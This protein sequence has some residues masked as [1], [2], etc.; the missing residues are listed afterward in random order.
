MIFEAIH[1]EIQSEQSCLNVKELCMLA[2]VSRSGYYKYISEDSVQKRLIREQKDLADF[3]L[4]K[5]AYDY[6]GYAKGYR[7]ICMRLARMGTLMN[8]KKVLRLMNKYGLKC[9]I[10]KANPYRRMAKALKT[11]VIAANLVKRQFKSHGPRQILLTDITYIRLN[12]SFCYLSVIIDAFTM[13]VL[14]YKLSN[15]L[16]VD[17]VLET[18]KMLMRNHLHSLN[19][20]TIIHS[21][22]GCHYT[23]V[24]F[25]ELIK[26]SNLRQSMSRRGNC[27]DN[28]P[29]ESFFGHMKDELAPYIK[30][31]K[32]INDADERISDWIDY[33]NNERYQVQLN[34]M[35]PNEYYHYI[36]TNQLPSAMMKILA[37]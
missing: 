14:A 35:A 16:E 11:D 26:D 5:E 15:S 23:S 24:K 8:H 22:Q 27:W 3:E 13:Q 34:G 33:Y 28:A 31:W 30:D 18:I 6:R 19:A 36:V 17:F 25:R 4:I 7:S 10:R 37:N 21:D 2:G 9:P 29:Q 12:G 32:T 1:K 20:T